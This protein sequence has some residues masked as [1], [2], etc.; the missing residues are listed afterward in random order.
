MNKNH[1]P[2]TFGVFKPVGHTVI[3]FYTEV[4]LQSTVV[5]LRA[6]GFSDSSM[7]HYSAAEM[8]AQADAEL[9]NASPVATAGYELVLVHTHRDLAKKGC[10]FLVVDAPTDDLAAQVAAL[11]HRIQP[12]TAQHYGRFMI[13]D[14]TEKTPAS[15][16]VKEVVG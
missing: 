1:P 16:G 6:L 4:E 15:V 14:L 2:T 13:E 11:V 5:A 7:V 10:C 12:A 9:L 8:A 3:G